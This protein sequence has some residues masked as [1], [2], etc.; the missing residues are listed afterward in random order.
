MS[1]SLRQ[2][3]SDGVYHDFVDGVRYVFIVQSNDYYA[4]KL[5]GKKYIFLVN[6]EHPEKHEV[7][8]RIEVI[9]EEHG[10]AHEDI[11]GQ[12]LTGPHLKITLKKRQ[13]TK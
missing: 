11:Y 8:F 5:R 2:G 3:V 7:R 9:D 12:Y 10:G 6:E 13:K 1:V 4:G